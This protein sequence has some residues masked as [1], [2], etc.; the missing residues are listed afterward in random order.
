MELAQI[1]TTHLQTLEPIVV[2]ITIIPKQQP[3]EE[4]HKAAITT[5]IDNKVLIPEAKVT[6]LQDHIVALL[7][8]VK[9]VAD[10]IAEVVEAVAEAVVQDHQE[11][12][13]DK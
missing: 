5:T 1:E 10:L 11:E 12:V 13:E 7:T 4:Q 8:E 9:A 2:P 6:L 3:E